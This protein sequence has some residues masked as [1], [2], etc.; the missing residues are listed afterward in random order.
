LGEPPRSRGRTGGHGGGGG[1]WRVEG[2]V[3]FATK[4]KNLCLASK[5]PGWRPA[6]VFVVCRPGDRL[7]HRIIA[8]LCDVPPQAE[9]RKVHYPELD[10][11][12]A[13]ALPGRVGV[14]SSEG[15]RP[16]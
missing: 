7:P 1:G 5:G 11:A 10:T 16:H 3:P 13:A 8:L 2:G 6:C 4:H 14:L 12:F 15:R 9:W